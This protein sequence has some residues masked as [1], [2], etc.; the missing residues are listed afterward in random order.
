MKAPTSST[1][2]EPA[3]KVESYAMR[4]L[5]AL[6]SIP[7]ACFDIILCG[8]YYGINKGLNLGYKCGMRAFL[9]LTC[10]SGGLSCLFA[11]AGGVAVGAVVGAV[12]IPIL[13]LSGTALAVSNMPINIVDALVNGE[14]DLGLARIEVAKEAV[15]KYC[16]GLNS[17][18]DTGLMRD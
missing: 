3:L 4:P 12:S 1:R 5:L 2:K 10:F 9:A 15:L 8:P 16:G 13:A 18:Q 17:S 11:I 6:A 14:I 7:F